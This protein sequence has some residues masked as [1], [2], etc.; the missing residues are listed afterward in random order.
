M[1][2]VVPGSYTLEASTTKPWGGVTASDA[3]L[4][5]RHATGA[6][7]QTGLRLVACDVNGNAAVNSGDALLINRRF[8]GSITTF[9]VGSWYFELPAVR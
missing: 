3:L 4:A 6:V 7:L 2:N 9:S 8:S 5:V 1:N